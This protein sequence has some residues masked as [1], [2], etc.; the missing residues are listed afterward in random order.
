MFIL[1]S[2]KGARK[3]VNILLRA[4]A[5]ISAKLNVDP[6]VEIGLTPLGMDARI[7]FRPLN[8]DLTCFIEI[9]VNHVYDKYCSIQPGELIVDCGAYIG[10]FTLQAANKVGEEGIVLAFEPNP[11]VFP[12]CRSNIERNEVNN[13]R[14]FQVALGDLDD[15]VPFESNRTNFGSSRVVSSKTGESGLAVQMKTLSQF[16]TCF[17]DKPIKLLKMDVEGSAERIVLGSEDLFR[18]NLVQNISAEVHPGEERLQSMLESYGFQCARENNYLYA[19]LDHRERSPTFPSAM[20]SKQREVS[21]SKSRVPA[22]TLLGKG[23]QP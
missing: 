13:V 9:F 5:A 7:A 18:R 3:A 10:E 11:Q 6:V 8:R 17:K 1:A 19:T 22:A 4:A 12:L 21:V 20:P 16:I 15:Q 14:L 2:N 23:S